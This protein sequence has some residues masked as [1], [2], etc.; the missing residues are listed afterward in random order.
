LRADLD[1][2][3]LRGNIQTRLR[4]L[5]QNDFDAIILAAA[6]LVRMSLHDRICS[7]IETTQSLPAAGQGALGLECREDDHELIQLLTPLN[8][9]LT[10][11]AVM[12]ER[13]V[14]KELGG[15]CKVPL[16]AFAEIHA[17]QLHLKGLVANLDASVMLRAEAVG[18]PE[19]AESLGKQVAYALISQ[20]ATDIL[21][22]FQ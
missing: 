10:Q 22:T 17:Q 8:H 4:R 21:R 11:Q 2:V 12:A 13:S 18:R 5:D 1:Y 19:Q 9:L 6:G 14:C 20:G 3:N 15:G 7:Y 16:A